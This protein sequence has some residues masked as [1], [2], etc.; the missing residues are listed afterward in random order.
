MD[1]A[2]PCQG[3]GDTNVMSV[4]QGQGKKLRFQLGQDMG[5]QSGANS[6][7]GGRMGAAKER[8]CLYTERGI[9]YRAYL[10]MHIHNIFIGM[11]EWTPLEGQSTYFFNQINNMIVTSNNKL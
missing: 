2:R 5:G 9:E 10:C 4:Q 8:H 6:Q 1:Q 3:K 7:I 11:V